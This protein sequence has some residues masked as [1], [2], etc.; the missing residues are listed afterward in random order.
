MEYCCKHLAEAVEK[1]NIQHYTNDEIDYFWIWGLPNCGD[2]DPE[3]STRELCI[4][5][6]PFCGELL[7]KSEK[8]D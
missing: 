7:S 2:L 8:G 3:Y 4:Y 1:R 5:Y 6:C